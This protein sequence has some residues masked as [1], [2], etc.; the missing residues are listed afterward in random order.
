MSDDPLTVLCDEIERKATPYAGGAIEVAVVAT[1][2]LR[3]VLAA[4]AAEGLAA[5]ALDGTTPAARFF[6]RTFPDRGF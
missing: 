4:R 2:L 6:R 5:E 3:L 1:E